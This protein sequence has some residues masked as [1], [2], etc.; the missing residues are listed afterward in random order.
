MLVGL[1]PKRG[2]DAAQQRA[3]W[4]QKFLLAFLE[5]PLF[6]GIDREAVYVRRMGFPSVPCDNTENLFEAPDRAKGR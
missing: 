5:S 3:D 1:P 6:Q 2:K 4:R